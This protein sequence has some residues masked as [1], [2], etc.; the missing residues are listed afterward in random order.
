VPSAFFLDP[1]RRCDRVQSRRSSRSC[2]PAEQTRSSEI[3]LVPM[4]RRGSDQYHRQMD[5]PSTNFQRRARSSSVFQAFGS[6]GSTL[7]KAIRPRRQPCAPSC[8]SG[9]QSVRPDPNR[10]SP[11]DRPREWRCRGL[12]L[13]YQEN[14]GRRGRRLGRRPRQYCFPAWDRAN[15]SSKAGRGSHPDGPFLRARSG[16]ST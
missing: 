8:F 12:L 14:P 5:R 16:Q 3:T 4:R 2:V 13:A 1:R 6:F 11:S 10:L 9:H 15:T 7:R